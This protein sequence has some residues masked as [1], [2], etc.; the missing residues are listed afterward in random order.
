MSPLS[1][2]TATA[3]Y[4]RADA[5]EASRA[6]AAARAAA[7]AAEERNAQAGD[8]AIGP[9]AAAAAVRDGLSTVAV[10]GAMGSLPAALGRMRDIALAASSGT[11]TDADRQTLQTEYSQ[12]SRQVASVVGSVSG[13]AQATSTPDKRDDQEASSDAEGRS[14]TDDP[15]DTSARGAGRSDRAVRAKTA[16]ASG[17]VA[18]K[19]SEST[20]AAVHAAP[21]AAGARAAGVAMFQQ[22]ATAAATPARPQRLSAVA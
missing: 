4:A 5:P 12:L 8:Q 2:V 18:A 13:N 20:P 11:L 22:H 7:R 16:S 17:T 1:S 3:A 10:V 6:A 9:A 21:H 15:G 19:R 14:G